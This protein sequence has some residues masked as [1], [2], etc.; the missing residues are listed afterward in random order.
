MTDSDELDPTLIGMASDT[1]G[2]EAEDS[3]GQSEPD[4]ISVR[5]LPGDFSTIVSGVGSLPE[6]STDGEAMPVDPQTR[7]ILR[8]EIAR[9]G[10]GAVIRGGDTL[11]GRDLAINVL[12]DAHRQDPEVVQRFLEEAQING[13]LQHPGIVPLHEMGQ[14]DDKRPFF[15]MKFV[16]GHT[17][18][19]LLLRRQSTEED[20]SRFIGI[21]QQVCQT[22]AYA[23]SRGVMHRDL[24]PSNIMV[25]AFGEVQ[26]M[27]WGLASL[28]LIARCG[29]PA[30]KLFCRRR[31]LR[32]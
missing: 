26:V 7:F 19:K 12:L 20:R 9:G 5:S 6:S 14:L 17:L 29:Q 8:E 27:D 4:P 28:G 31:L 25:G 21:F 30:G 10:M 2:G 23:H 24:K 13:Q 1:D 18:T 11:L 22:V 3:F 16:Q 32:P 15:A